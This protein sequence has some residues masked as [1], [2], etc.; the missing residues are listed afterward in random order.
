MEQEQEAQ[1][2]REIQKE[3]G[4]AIPLDNRESAHAPFL[5]PVP[6]PTDPPPPPPPPQLPRVETVGH[7]NQAS[8]RTIIGLLILY[9]TIMVIFGGVTYCMYGPQASTSNSKP[10]SYEPD[11]VVPEKI[12]KPPEAH[13]LV[14]N[15]ELPEVEDLA[16]EHLAIA[17]A[18]QKLVGVE[19]LT[20][21]A[22]EQLSNMLQAARRNVE[23]KKSKL[24]EEIYKRN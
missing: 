16:R 3:L 18:R 12:C 11:N 14:E 6:A 10:E 8:V 4:I 23:E 17:A 22:L 19:R 21:F 9:V 13:N 7:E 24:E 5:P 15:L 2:E 1:L 20:M